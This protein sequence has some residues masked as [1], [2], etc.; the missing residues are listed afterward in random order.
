VALQTDR[1]CAGNALP[2]HMISTAF[3]TLGAPAQVR[4]PDRII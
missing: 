1:R 3:H 2:T 4:L